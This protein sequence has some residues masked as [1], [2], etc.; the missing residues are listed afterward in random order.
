MARRGA[1]PVKSGKVEFKDPAPFQRR[2]YPWRD[3]AEQL[4][5]K[6]GQWALV[7]TDIPL[8]VVWARNAG[9]VKTVSPSRGFEATARKTDKKR[10]VAGEV[11]MRYVPEQ[12]ETRSNG[13][14]ERRKKR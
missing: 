7:L 6:P 9:R 1:S 5:A 2:Q 4:R 10:G 14:K 3:I 12:D 13:T 8:S 11:Y